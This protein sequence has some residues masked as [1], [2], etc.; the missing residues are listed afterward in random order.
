MNSYK[1]NLARDK[2]IILLKILLLSVL[3]FLPILV[4]TYIKLSFTNV[5]FWEFFGIASCVINF[6]VLG[7]QKFVNEVIIDKKERKIAVKQYSLFSGATEVVLN[8]S[9]VQIQVSKS[10]NKYL[11]SNQI[12]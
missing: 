1:A 6:F 7:K 3:S 5:Q 8:F 4:F 10:E 9:E 12:L 11:K 2:R